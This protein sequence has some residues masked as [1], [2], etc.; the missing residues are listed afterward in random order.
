M[1]DYDRV[2][3]MDKPLDPNELLKLHRL[4][5][6]KHEKLSSYEKEL[7]KKYLSHLWK[8]NVDE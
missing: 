8:G 4:W 7:I 6:E 1:S 5:L 2:V 3:V